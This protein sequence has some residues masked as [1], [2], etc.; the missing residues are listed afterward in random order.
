MKL[1]RLELHVST[2]AHYDLV[3]EL[4]SDI[5]QAQGIQAGWQDVNGIKISFCSL[6][7]LAGFFSP[8]FVFRRG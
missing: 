5:T 7:P 1:Y 8:T 3:M 2:Y 6:L 4:M